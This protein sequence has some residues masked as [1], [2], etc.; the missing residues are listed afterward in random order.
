MSLPDIAGLAGA[1]LVAIAY[2]GNI[3]GRLQATDVAYSLLNLGGAILI[4]TSLWFSWNLA[5]AIIEVFWGLTSI[6]GLWR[7]MMAQPRP[8]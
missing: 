5:A 3:Q 2:F 7:A 6:Y 4:L 8:R 1:V